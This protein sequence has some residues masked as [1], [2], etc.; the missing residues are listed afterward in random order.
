M[1]GSLLEKLVRLIGLLALVA[2]AL[3]PPWQ[4]AYKTKAGAAES[5]SVGYHPIWNPP[6]AMH[7]EN[8][9]IVD[10]KFRVNLIILGVELAVVLVALN[11][12]VMALKTKE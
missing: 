7:E 3:V 4:F 11:V 10:P 12:G 2:F 8:D 1:R 6:D 5:K 9:N